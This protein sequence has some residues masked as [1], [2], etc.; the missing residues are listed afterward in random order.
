LNRATPATRTAAPERTS[1][2]RLEEL[3]S[4]L[5]PAVTFHGGPV[6]PHATVDTV[7]Y[8]QYWTAPSSSPDYTAAQQDMNGLDQFFRTITGSP[9]LSMLGEY[10]V[11]KGQFFTRNVVNGPA[12]NTT[13]TESTIQ[14]MLQSQFLSGALGAPSTSNVVFV[15]LPPN[16]HSQ[17][18]DQ[19]SFMGHHS[20]V[21]V[22]YLQWEY[23]GSSWVPIVTWTQVAYAV[24][25]HPQ[26]NLAD[27]GYNLTNLS[28]DFQKQTEISSHE[29]AEAV[30][31]PYDY[32]DSSGNWHGG[33]WDSNGN[34]I[35]DLANQQVA[36]LDGYAVQREWSNYWNRSVAPLFD[37]GNA[38]F[39][40]GQITQYYW[41]Q[42]AEGRSGLVMT[43]LYGF[44][45]V[46]W[47][48]SDGTWSGW[49]LVG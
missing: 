43:D 21:T 28:T 44:T 6:I 4:R 33:W 32:Q 36:W 9:Y 30:T 24:V 22:P 13:V 40:A 38:P 39:I 14:G 35:G 41:T 2:P 10:G 16:V 46:D 34:E 47:Q 11:G 37:A 12:A 31:N 7:Y 23:L 42:T 27:N 25:P 45:N 48:L 1:R 17:Y 3:E 5:V 49:Y 26:G 8:G 20:A 15:F 19:N 18:D 29:L